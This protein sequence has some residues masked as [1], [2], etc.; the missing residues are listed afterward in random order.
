MYGG[1]KVERDFKKDLAFSHSAEDLPIWHEVYSK[2]FPSMIEMVSYRA[3][4]EHQ[5]SGI[6]RGIY[7]NHAKEILVDEKIRGRNEK[8]G[9]VYTDI[10]IE[11]I[12]NAEQKKPGWVCKPLRADYIAYLIAPAGI[13]YLLPV[14]QMQN[15]W[16]KNNIDWIKRY[17]M[18]NAKTKVVN[19]TYTTI[20]TPVPA[21]ILF[22]AIGAELRINFTAFECV[23]NG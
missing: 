9:K 3:N 14:I 23:S 12:A 10:L 8:T 13:C 1:I 19:T 7:L 2:A 22:Q 6:D 11:H 18:R 15:A 17:G 21:K 5:N 4:G 20:S 16:K